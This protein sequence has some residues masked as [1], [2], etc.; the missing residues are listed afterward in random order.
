MILQKTKNTRDRARVP[1]EDSTF[2]RSLSLKS[3]RDGKRVDIALLLNIV[4]N[5]STYIINVP[6]CL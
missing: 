5:L 6:L 1:T 2:L 4:H 3:D